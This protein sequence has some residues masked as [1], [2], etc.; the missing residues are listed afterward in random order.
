MGRFLYRICGQMCI[1]DSLIGAVEFPRIPATLGVYRSGGVVGDKNP[2]DTAKEL[3]HMDMRCNPG[4][5]LFVRKCFHIGVLAERHRTYEQV[6]VNYL[7][8]VRV[9]DVSRVSGPVNFNLLSG[10]A[11]DMHRSL[12]LNFLFVDV[13]AELRIHKRFFSRLAAVLQ[14]RCV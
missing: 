2:R 10:L 7:A 12:P 3:E 4:V 6:G 14:I 1:R 11:G 5:G 8:G 9:G 13:E